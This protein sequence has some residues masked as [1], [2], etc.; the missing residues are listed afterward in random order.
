MCRCWWSSPWAS[1]L[2][3]LTDVLRLFVSLDVVGIDVVGLFVF[4]RLRTVVGLLVE[5]RLVMV[6]GSSPFD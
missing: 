1:R 5:L 6:T 3:K 4:S 2:V